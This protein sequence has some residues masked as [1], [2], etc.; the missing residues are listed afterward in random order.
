M[1]KIRNTQ[2][3]VSNKYGSNY[4]NAFKKKVKEMTK[5]EKTVCV[6]MAVLAIS[7]WALNITILIIHF[8]K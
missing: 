4:D 3:K 1:P 7:F 5:F 6:L 8:S 2:Q